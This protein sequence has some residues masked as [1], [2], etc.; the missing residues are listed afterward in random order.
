MC[1][2]TVNEINVEKGKEKGGGGRDDLGPLHRPAF[3]L[4]FA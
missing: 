1:E 4:V 2:K 3:S